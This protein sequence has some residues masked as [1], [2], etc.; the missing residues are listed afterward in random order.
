MDRPHNRPK[1]QARDESGMGAGAGHSGIADLADFLRETEPPAPSG[2]IYA[3][4][5][6]GGGGQSYGGGS[7]G[8]PPST[9]SGVSTNG[10]K[11][12]G[13]WRGMF[14]RRKKSLGHL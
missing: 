14:G 1:F 3:G 11:E 9:R 4:G 13:G 5:G 7:V 10:G 6:G 12:E 8:G 2:P